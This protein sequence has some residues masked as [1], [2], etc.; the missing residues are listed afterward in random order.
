MVIAVVIPFVLTVIAGKKKTASDKKSGVPAK[1]LEE[2][3]ADIAASGERSREQS[4][5]E[6]K[7][8]LT[9]RVIE[10]EEVGDGVFSEGIMGEGLAMVPENDT[11]YAPWSAC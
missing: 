10:L 3:A 1:D 9:G 7:A 2:M 11:L 8:F 6:L 4:K 5:I